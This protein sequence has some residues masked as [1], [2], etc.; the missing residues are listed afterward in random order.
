METGL[1]VLV[2]SPVMLL[3]SVRG[4]PGKVSRE[5]RQP[6][7]SRFVFFFPYVRNG[8]VRLIPKGIILKNQRGR[9]YYYF[10]STQILKADS[11]S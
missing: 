3:S 4:I 6:G 11:E 7:R 10:I 8:I 9:E 5:G 2:F 1:A